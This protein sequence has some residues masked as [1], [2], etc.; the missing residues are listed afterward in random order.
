M[1]SGGCLSLYYIANI[2]RLT[3]GSMLEVL[4]SNF[5][6]TAIAKGLSKT[7]IVLVHCLK[8][9]LIP[10]ISYLGPATAGMLAGSL[11]IEKIFVI[12]GIGRQFV[13]SAFARDYT[14]ALG[15]ILFY[16][17]LVIGFNAVVDIMYHILDPKLRNR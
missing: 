2:A 16:C 13:D 12:P 9:T 6:R 17:T 7:R 11:V 5:V 8:P 3:R 1:F 4:T 14:M 10:V 15:M